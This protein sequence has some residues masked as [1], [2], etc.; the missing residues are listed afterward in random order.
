LLRFESI[1]AERASGNGKRAART[2][3][4][5]GVAAPWTDMP[6]TGYDCRVGDEPL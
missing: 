6:D 2:G 5:T 3:T 1:I 4:C